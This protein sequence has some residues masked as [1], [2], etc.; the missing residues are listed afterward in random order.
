MATYDSLVKDVEGAL[1]K[2]ADDVDGPC[3]Q[4]QHGKA[5][6]LF[7]SITLELRSELR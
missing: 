3:Y 7:V 5:V 2:C 1:V 4:E 6:I